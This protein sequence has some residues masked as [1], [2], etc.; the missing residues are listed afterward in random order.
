MFFASFGPFVQSNPIAQ[1]TLKCD[2]HNSI[3]IITGNPSGTGTDGKIK[4][5]Y[6]NPQKNA[7]GRITCSQS[8]GN[9]T[10]ICKTESTP[11]TL[12]TNVGDYLI[13]TRDGSDTGIFCINNKKEQPVVD[14]TEIWHKYNYIYIKI[15]G[16]CFL[17]IVLLVIISLLGFMVYWRIH[18]DG[19]RTPQN[20]LV[21]QDERSSTA[22]HIGGVESV[23]TT[24]HGKPNEYAMQQP[25]KNV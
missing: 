19:V 6:F 7:R 24:A 14:T 8:P 16:H 2:I 9:E 3:I 22:G 1:T 18:G 10:S 21:N 4:F 5:Q 13:L 12:N 11:D 23:G 20:L 15:S 17:G 25:T